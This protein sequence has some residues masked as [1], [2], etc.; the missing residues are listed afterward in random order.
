[1][2]RGWDDPNLILSFES[3]GDVKGRLAADFVKDEVGFT[4]GSL[5]WIYSIVRYLEL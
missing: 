2:A 1:M 3:N 5:A 4:H